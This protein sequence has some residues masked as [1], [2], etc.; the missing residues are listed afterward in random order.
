MSDDFELAYE[1]YRGKLTSVDEAD[2]EIQKSSEYQ[3]NLY[4]KEASDEAERQFQELVCSAF[5]SQGFFLELAGKRCTVTVFSEEILGIEINMVSWGIPKFSQNK[6][7][8]EEDLL[9]RSLFEISQHFKAGIRNGV[10]AT[11]ASEFVQNYNGVV[12]DMVQAQKVAIYGSRLGAAMDRTQRVTQ[13][14]KANL[15]KIYPDGFYGHATISIKGLSD[16]QYFLGA[17]ATIS[18]PLLSASDG[19]KRRIE[20]MEAMSKW[21]KLTALFFL[22]G[23]IAFAF[24]GYF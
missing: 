17:F 11:Q 2:P 13:S 14:A 6:S 12:L 23:V 21:A 19:H 7:L 1:K 15:E 9:Q 20:I 16:F 5:S 3:N 18:E 24:S 8:D 10:N 4:R 22:F